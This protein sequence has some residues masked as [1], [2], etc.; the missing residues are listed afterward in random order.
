MNLN[1]SL[2]ATQLS[3]Y[4]GCTK[5]DSLENEQGTQYMINIWTNSILDVRDHC[6]VGCK[7]FCEV[8]PDWRAGLHHFVI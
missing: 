7:L 4:R 8:G 1:Q 2:D 6:T 3:A 5:T